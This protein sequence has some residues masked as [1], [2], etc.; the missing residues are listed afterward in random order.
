MYHSSLRTYRGKD[1]QYH[2]IWPPPP[3]T[4]RSDLMET[5]DKEKKEI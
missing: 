3:G 2:G 1:G 5:V 4:A